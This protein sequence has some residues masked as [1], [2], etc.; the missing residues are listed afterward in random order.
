MILE[1][2]GYDEQK[3]FYIFYELFNKF[4]NLTVESCE[5]ITLSEENITFHNTDEHA[6]R[7]IVGPNLDIEEPVY[8]N[9]E[10]VYIIRLTDNAGYLLLI[11]TNITHILSQWIFKSKQRVK[12]YVRTYFGNNLPD[13][14][15]VEANSITLDKKETAAKIV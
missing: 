5:K 7:S 2:S 13:W 15:K 14:E 12:Q 11:N 1:R 9:P 6:P 10:V 4:K 3:G 8:K